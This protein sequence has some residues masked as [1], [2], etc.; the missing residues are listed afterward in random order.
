MSD[1]ATSIA[2]RSNAEPIIIAARYS[3]RLVTRLHF[4]GAFLVEYRQ[5]H[6]VAPM[7]QSARIRRTCWMRNPVQ[8]VYAN[9]RIGRLPERLRF[10]G[11]CACATQHSVAV[12]TTA[13][14]H[15]PRCSICAP[16]HAARAGSV[17]RYGTPAGATGY[18]EFV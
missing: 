5:R 14:T 2:K 13:S 17:L 4:P 9:L 15:R 7:D 1:M 6:K 16:S 12:D 11:Y 3:A 10:D 8:P 18:V